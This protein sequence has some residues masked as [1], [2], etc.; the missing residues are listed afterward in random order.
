MGN[1]LFLCSPHHNSKY[2]PVMLKCLKR[3]TTKNINM[4]LGNT[5]KTK[6]VTLLQNVI[7][8]IKSSVSVCFIGP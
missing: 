8:C 5:S 3:I 2:M 7:Y 4:G 6:T 1:V